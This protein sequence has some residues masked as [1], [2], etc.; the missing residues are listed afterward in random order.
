[1]LSYPPTEG[2]TPCQAVVFTIS[3]EKTNKF[4]KKQF[5][6]ALRYKNLLLCLQ[7]AMAQYFF[8]QWSLRKERLPNFKSKRSWYRTKLLV[9]HVRKEE[10]QLS[11]L[12]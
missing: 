9:A 5:I 10:E 4:G 11:Y 7:G 8:T 3:K 1:M 12:T 6:G 2:L